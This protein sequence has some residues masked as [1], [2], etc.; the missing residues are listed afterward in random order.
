MTSQSS[1]TGMRGKGMS[2]RSTP[3]ISWIR[4]LGP[5]VMGV[6]AGLV[7]IHLADTGKSVA[8]KIGKDGTTQIVV[9]ANESF[10]NVLENALNNHRELVE[11]LLHGRKYYKI[12]DK[13]L[14]VLASEEGAKVAAGLR[15][16]LWDLNG[17]FAVPGTL[18]GA[19]ER[20][21]TALDDL[22]KALEDPE[23]NEA[24]PFLGRLWTLMMEQQRIFKQRVFPAS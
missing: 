8:V 20:M 14:P 7:T 17:P 16:M 6:L 15:K 19:D 13:I 21:V 3:A 11:A 9:T 24:S 10:D 12:D 2:G 18:R 4:V 5:L 23:A 1:E 22:D